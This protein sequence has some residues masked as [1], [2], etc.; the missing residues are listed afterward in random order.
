MNRIIEELG[1]EGTFEGHLVQ[2]PY[3]E[4]GMAG[5]I[6]TATLQSTPVPLGQVAGVYPVCHSTFCGLIS[7]AGEAELLAGSPVFT[8]CFLFSPW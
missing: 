4:R 1:L 8:A 5:S 6:P 2:L 7:M 3:H